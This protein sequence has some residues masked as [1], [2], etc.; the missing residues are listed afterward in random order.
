MRVWVDARNPWVFCVSIVS[1]AWPNPITSVWGQWVQLAGLCRPCPILEWWGFLRVEGFG[2]FR[3]T[4]VVG[5][6]FFCTPTWMCSFL[7]GWRVSPR[8]GSWAWSISSL[9]PRSS[10]LKCHSFVLGW[11]H[12][13]WCCVYWIRVW[14]NCP[15]SLLFLSWC[16]NF[17]V[18]CLFCD[19][20]GEA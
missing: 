9:P 4:G 2:D 16:R 14:W 10:Y 5:W 8:G 20:R 15:V 6:F 13:N 17:V 7:L 1:A 19:F 11:L 18:L 3:D 12:V